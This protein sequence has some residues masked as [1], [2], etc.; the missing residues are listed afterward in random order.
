MEQEA[1]DLG[2]SLGDAVEV[3][4]QILLETIES[5]EMGQPRESGRTACGNSQNVRAPIAR[6]P[7][8]VRLSGCPIGVT[9]IWHTHPTLKG[10]REP[11]H[12][13][14]DWANVVFTDLDASMV[15]GVETSELIV[16]SEDRSAMIQ[17]FQNALGL[18]V[19]G[20]NDVVH[21]VLSGKI[22]DPDSARE[23][24]RQEL[25]PLVMRVNTSF[26]VLRDRVDQLQHT[27]QPREPT[28]SMKVCGCAYCTAYSHGYSGKTQAL[29][30][31]AKACQ[32]MLYQTTAGI[33]VRQLAVATMIGNVVGQLTDKVLFGE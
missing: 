30:Q 14:P 10:L 31:R 24:V 15:V 13:L 23:R 25:Q 27:I 22:P 4:E 9:G 5:A 6:F 2:F 21:A 11:E 29:H 12:S 8:A 26:P 33:S 20:V 19:E 7:E 32:P 18:N 28:V 16:T 17:A 3:Q 1:S